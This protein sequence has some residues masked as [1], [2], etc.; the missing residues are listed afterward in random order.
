MTSSL[1][2]IIAR[3]DAAKKLLSSNSVHFLHNAAINI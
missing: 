1:L 3:I 2:M